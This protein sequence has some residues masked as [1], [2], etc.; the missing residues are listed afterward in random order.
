MKTIR[1]E[2][3]K[4]GWSQCEL[5]RRARMTPAD[6]GKIESGRIVPYR[7]QV[8]KLAKA[9]EISADMTRLLILHGENLEAHMGDQ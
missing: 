6:V 2:R 1:L 9:L 4:K 5:S 3:E 7:S 8:K